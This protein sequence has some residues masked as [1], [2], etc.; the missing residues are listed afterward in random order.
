MS[1][2]IFLASENIPVS[3]LFYLSFFC[4]L[5]EKQVLKAN[6]KWCTN[7]MTPLKQRPHHFFYLFFYLK[8]SNKIGIFRWDQNSL[9][10]TNAALR[11]NCLIQKYNVKSPWHLYFESADLSQYF[12]Y[13]KTVITGFRRQ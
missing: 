10:S 13:G 6:P 1:R 11:Q 2:K 9:L 7:S 12:N 4:L 5:T 8:L 3:E